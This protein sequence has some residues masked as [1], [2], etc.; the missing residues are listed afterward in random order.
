ME[1]YVFPEG[2]LWGSSAWALGTEGGMD[3]D[4]KATTVLEEFGH[5]RPGRFYNGVGPDTT[6][7][8]RHDYERFAQMAAEIGHTAFRTGML[9][10]RL[11]PDGTHVSESAVAFYRNLFGAFKERGMEVSVV[12][13]WYD[14]PVFLEDR[15]GFTN[16]DVVD[17][18]VRY[19]KVAFELFS[20]LVDIWYVYNE[21]WVDVLMKYGN[22]SCYPDEVDWDKFMKAPYN[23]VVAH[24]LAV[25]AFREGGYPGKIGTV[26]ARSHVYGASDSA[27]D[28]AAVTEYDAIVHRS[29][30]MPIF[31]GKV[32]EGWL[33]IVRRSGV[34]LDVREGDDELLA[35]NTADMLGLNIYMPYRVQFDGARRTPAQWMELNLPTTGA[36]D[37]EGAE[38]FMMSAPYVWPE[39][40]MNKD[41]GWE[42]YP[43]VM[44]D[45]IMECSELYPDV[46]LRITEN[47]M[48][49]QDE[50]RFRDASGQVQD[51]YRIEFHRR[52]LVWVQRAIEAG[53]KLTGYQLWSFV[54]LWSPSNQFKNCYGLIELDL[55]TGAIRR[56]KSA[57]WYQRVCAE[58]AVEA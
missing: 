16:R 39:A 52:H 54:D 9:W 34:E 12:L 29:F 36:H 15:G 47:G 5:L 50:G 24:A 42:I 3:E 33:D 26:Q 55:A 10:A 53:A 11:M 49:V 20:D 6:L 1:R 19:C 32:D 4:G 28:R 21:P 25:K 57:D 45:C 51:D 27:E 31:G 35:E 38:A 44:F 40:E 46:E 23:M 8:W 56:K 30:E 13:Y 22:H 37:K 2:F 58:N 48:G 18:F 14:M 41:R 17:D 7:D 43:K